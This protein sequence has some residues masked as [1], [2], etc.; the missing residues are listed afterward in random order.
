MSSTP[1]SPPRSDPAAA[2]REAFGH[3]AGQRWG[4][5]IDA[6]EPVAD[7][8]ADATITLR[9][10]RNLAALQQH[11][12][13]VYRVALAELSK[14]HANP[15]YQPYATDDG[16]LGLALRQAD[17]RLV[18][19]CNRPDP[20]QAAAEVA[21]QTDQAAA[22]RQAIGLMGLGDGY[23]LTHLAQHPPQLFMSQALAVYVFES[24]PELLLAC[25]KLHD[26]AGGGGPIADPRFLWFIG[27]GADARFEQAFEAEDYLPLPHALVRQGPQGQSIAD[28]YTKAKQRISDRLDAQRRRIHNRYAARTDEQYR[29]LFTGQADRR[30]RVMLLTS[31]FTTVLQHATA[32][33]AAAFA[34]LGWDTELV[35]EPADHHVVT[36]VTLLRTLDRFDP[37]LVFNLDHLRSEYRDTIPPSLPYVCWAQDHLPTLTNAKAGASVNEREF[38]LTMLGPLY[39]KLWSYPASQ[40]LPIPKLTRVPPRPRSWTSDGPDLIYVS[41]ASHAPDR[42]KEMTMERAGEEP[43][44]RRVLEQAADRIRAVYAQGGSLP[45]MGDVGRIV[46]QVLDEHG[47]SSLA[48]D[49]RSLLVHLLHHPLNDG[50]YRQ[51]A[52]RWVADVADETGL[53]LQLF[54]RGWDT[55]ERFARY[56]QG[57]VAY[58]PALEDLTRRAKACLQIIPSYCLH[59]RMLDGLAA[60]GFFLVRRHS[61]DTVFTELATLLHEHADAEAESVED[62]RASLDAAHRARFD[63]LIDAAR[64]LSDIGTP[65]DTVAWMR[66]AI[67]S[68]MIPTHGQP[69][70]Y[71]DQTSFADAAELRRC[72]DRFLPEE[73]LRH[74]VAAAQRQRVEAELTYTAGLRRML[75]LIAARFPTPARAAA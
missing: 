59:Q 68:R 44:R 7:A 29:T 74:E 14:T 12:P 8:S 53:D 48:A 73:R 75:S 10:A 54:G 36:N 31:R 47:A 13:Q 71:F 49:K 23:L 64:A 11:R 4:A 55:H 15:R 35:I 21:A 40:L 22:S 34:E 18:F 30:P 60:G 62:A 39:R 20:R 70:P 24:D 65:V 56:A 25:L 5:A 69:L 38:V 45:A 1:T 43:H 61:S 28:R 2:L 67:T 50:L 26:W 42:L 58:G 52:L 3:M 66:D 9:L 37:D 16:T 6:L 19:M 46:D 51:Q 63:E 27:A 72:L 57:P 33:A 32:D 41:N 17:G